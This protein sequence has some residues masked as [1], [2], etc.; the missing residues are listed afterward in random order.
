MNS[1]WLNAVRA[2][3]NEF[4]TYTVT[5]TGAATHTINSF[6]VSAATDVDWGDGSQDTYTGTAQRTHSY[7]A[8]GTWQV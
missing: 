1:I 7:S 4:A 2:Q 3:L 5:T 6:G 8:A